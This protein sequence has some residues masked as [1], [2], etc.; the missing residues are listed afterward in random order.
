MSIILQ[1]RV[2]FG[3]KGRS[4]LNFDIVL[5]PFITT[6]CMN[7]RFLNNI[8]RPPVFQ[9]FCLSRFRPSQISFPLNNYWTA[10]PM[11]FKLQVWVNFGYKGHSPLNFD[12]VLGPF[13][14]TLCMKLRFL[15]NIFRTAAC[16][17]GTFIF[18]IILQVKVN[19]GHNPLIFDRLI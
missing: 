14:T 2:N 10:S 13:I 9:S 11:K 12:I 1:V 4:P 17:T 15:N 18:S 5:G 19:L 7:L 3:Y 6:L 8:F 16:V